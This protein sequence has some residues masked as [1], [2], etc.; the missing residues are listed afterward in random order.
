VVYAV[1]VSRSNNDALALTDANRNWVCAVPHVTLSWSVGS[2][3]VRRAP[4]L[5]RVA[6]SAGEQRATGCLRF[7]REQG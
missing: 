5:V 3:D 6:T 7:G 4:A 2:T 1:T